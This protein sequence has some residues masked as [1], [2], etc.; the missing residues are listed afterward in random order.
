MAAPRFTRRQFETRLVA[1]ARRDAHFRRK[2]LADPNQT[3]ATEL[4]REIPGQAQIRV[5]EEAENVFYVVLPFVP[6]G[7]RLSD[8]QV[9]KI[10]K[11]ELTHRNPCWGLGDGLD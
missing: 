1:K 7:L 9:L 6:P 5:V 8:E 10:A 2:L 4:G 11:R 3:Y